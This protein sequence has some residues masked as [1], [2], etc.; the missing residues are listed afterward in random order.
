MTKPVVAAFDFDGT[1][2]HGDSFLPFLRYLAGDK[3]YALSML[4]LSPVLLGYALKLVKNHHA[5]ARVL[6]QFFT[7]QDVQRIQQR[8]REFAQHQLPQRINPKA[9]ARLRWHQQ[10]GHRCVIVSA[11]LECYL[12]PWAASVGVEEVIGSRLGIAGEAYTGELALPNCYGVEKSRRL[13]ALLGEREA[14]ILYAYGDS[15]GD[16]E[17]LA[18]ADYGY[19][20]K[21][22]D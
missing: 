20:R 1:L 15:K 4:Q 16:K 2:T 8:A 18:M 10:Q 13:T 21:M 17:L 6:A 5:K 12:R 11:S 3:Q 19:Y 9:L 7:G 14:Y 22:P